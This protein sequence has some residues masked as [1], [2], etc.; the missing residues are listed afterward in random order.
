MTQSIPR[1][2]SLAVIALAAAGGWVRRVAVERRSAARTLAQRDMELAT[3]RVEKNRM[4]QAQIRQLRE[5]DR[6]KNHLISNLSHELKTPISLITG[7]AELLEDRYPDE[8]LVAGIL[9]GSRRLAEHLNSLLDY[10]ALISGTMPLYVTDVCL[11]EIVDHA[12]AI[13]EAALQRRGLRPEVAIAPDAPCVRGD[14][15]RVTQILLALLDNAIKHTPPGGRLGV[16]I[17]PEGGGYRLTVWDS[18][19]GV[20]ASE[21]RRIF[22]PFHQVDAGE[23]PNGGLGLGL[24]IVDRL[25]ALHGGRASMESRPEGGSCFHVVLPAA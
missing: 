15:R 9:D 6:L 22:E 25:A 21:R 17:V 23:R 10:S 20:E 18:G 4:Q 16:A 19:P 5:V 3:E 24:A 12:L 11:P 13:E 8:P 1:T 2:L 14:A 7:Y